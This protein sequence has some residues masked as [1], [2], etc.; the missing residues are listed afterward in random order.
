LLEDLPFISILL[1][2]KASPDSL[3][4]LF[5]QRVSVFFFLKPSRKIQSFILKQQTP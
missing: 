2:D 3:K 4:S 5:T 1:E